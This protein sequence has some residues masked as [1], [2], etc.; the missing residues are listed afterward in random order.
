MRYACLAVLVLLQGCLLANASASKRLSDT[1]NL[2]NRSTRWGQLAD[3]AHMVEPAYRPL[4][5][6]NHRGWGQA[7]QVAD[8]EVV[9]IEL[10][11]DS[12]SA[13]ALVSYEWYLPDALNLHQTLI[14]QR[15]SRVG[16]GMYTLISEAVVQGDARLLGGK[17]V[18]LA[19][20]STDAETL[21]LA[22]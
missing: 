10:A 18:A 2:M 15:W 16:K 19:T 4:F 8:S 22:E 3:A 1:V 11:P 5:I 6:A 17:A 14:R 12:E 13:L 21:G 9:H 7:I 20:P